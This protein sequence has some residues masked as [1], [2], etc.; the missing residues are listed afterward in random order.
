M[1]SPM[2]NKTCSGLTFRLFAISFFLIASI[3]SFSQ[4]DRSMKN[5]LIEP[6]EKWW[7]GA[8]SDGYRMP[9]ISGYEI[10][11]F[12]NNKSNQAQPLLLSNHGRYIWS[13]EP[14]A[15]KIRTDS[16]LITGS[17][18]TTVEYITGRAGNTLREAYKYACKSFFPSS[19]KMP[20]ELMFRHPQYNTWIELTYNQNQKDV[21]KYANGII[22]NGFPAGIIMIDDTWQE[23]YG[24]WNFH[25][26]RF[27]DPKYMIDSL[28]NM[29]FKIMVW[30]CPFISPDCDVYR[31][32]RDDGLLIKEKGTDEPAMIHW[33]NGVSA[34]LD[35]TN[36]GAMNWIKKQ[37]SVLTDSLSIDGFKF[38][39]GD[40]AF[41]AGNFECY[42]NVIPNEHSRI[43]GQL[44]LD[45]PLNE[46]RAMWKM[47]GQ[48]LAQRLQ[49]K[50]HNWEDLQ[51]L[52][53]N[54]IAQ[55]LC[56]YAF[57]CPDLIGGGEYLSFINLTSIDQDLVVRSAQCHALMPMMQFSVAPWRV[58]DAE[59]LKAIQKSIGIR[60][61]FSQLLL[62]LAKASAI[63]GEPIIRS[64][65]YVFP[66]NGYDQIKDQ[67]M[68]GDS[69]LVAPMLQKGIK[70]RQVVIPP[71][72]WIGDDNKLNKGPATIIVQVPI[73]RLPYFRKVK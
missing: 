1:K 57:T 51:T 16:I 58:L 56:G 62:S 19:G 2:R 34:L 65:E 4:N 70:S 37:L 10:D 29:G 63:D 49:D 64:M 8:I 11:L 38:D 7:G 52:I 24:K 66:D 30:I 44:G 60:T 50:S 46:Y 68:L 61:Q 47:G 55:G 67:F 23:D 5:I 32:L 72:K 69:I 54:I 3:P 28:H 9:F 22:R 15:F 48:P 26:A 59:H 25:P 31:V 53:P 12:G 35:L 18:Q 6:G 27:K 17:N 21:L 40:A 43:Y 42:K 39:A 14:F 45:Y 33:W 73:E 13:D 36:P 20:D 71:G 41:Y